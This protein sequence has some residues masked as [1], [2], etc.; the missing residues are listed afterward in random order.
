MRFYT[1]THR[2][3]FGGPMVTRVLGLVNRRRRWCYQCYELGYL[4]TVRECVHSSIGLYWN[5]RFTISAGVS[6]WSTT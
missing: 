6:S 3:L 1:R 2:P 5:A 4:W